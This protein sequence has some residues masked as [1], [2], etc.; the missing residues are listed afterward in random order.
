MNRWMYPIRLTALASLSLLPGMACTYSAT[1]PVVGAAGGYVAVQV[2]TQ[3]G[4]VW[5]M[6]GGSFASIVSAR[7][8]SGSGAVTV[9]VFPNPNK[10]ARSN[11]LSGIV[12]RNCGNPNSI[13][14]RSAVSGR[15]PM[16]VF[17]STVTEQGR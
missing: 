16:I 15:V 5:E 1:S 2:Y 13:G 10:A 14:G 11:V 6:T 7:S 9:Y 8:G 17:R 12:Y 4:C 3:P